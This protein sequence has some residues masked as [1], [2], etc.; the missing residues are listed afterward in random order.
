MGNFRAALV[1]ILA[2]L[3]MLLSAGPAFAQPGPPG[4]FP[5]PGH[6]PP[7][8]GQR[9]PPGM[10]P[11]G[12]QQPPQQ[13]PNQPTDQ[14]PV[15]HPAPKPRSWQEQPI[16]DATI[17]DAMQ[18]AIQFIWKSINKDGNWE[19]Y[20]Q[21]QFAADT[22]PGNQTAGSVYSGGTALILMSLLRAGISADDARWDKAFKSIVEAQ[23]AGT[24]ARSM[25]A[26]LFATMNRPKLLGKLMDAEKDYQLQAVFADGSYGY[27]PPT[28]RAD[29]MKP[30]GNVHRDMSAT[31][32]GILAMWLLSDAD[33]EMPSRYWK[34]I[35][36][37][38]LKSQNDDG[39]WGYRR[40][41]GK[42]ESYQAMTLAGVASLFVVW[43]K[44]YAA[45]CNRRPD[46]DLV[47]GI[48]KGLEWMAKH[49]DAG[50]G[51]GHP[52]W[53]RG[54]FLG[55]TLYGVERVAVAGGLKY[56]GK[57][58]W[59]DEGAR[60]LLYSQR[61]DGSWAADQNNNATA[62]V[63][64]AY[65][66]LFLSYGRAPVVFN[67]LAWS[68]A[69][70]WN[71][72]PR[73]LA[74]LTVWMDKTYERLFNWQVMPIGQ[75]LEELLDAPVLLISG[76]GELDFDDE[77]KQ[78]L[79]QYVLRGGMLLADPVGGDG[80]FVRSFTALLRE[81][82]G[83]LE[84]EEMENDHPLF[85][86]HFNLREPARGRMPVPKMFALSNGVRTLAV[87][88]TGELGCTWQSYNVARG[89]DIFRFGGNVMMYV[90][91]RGKGLLGRG[92]SYT[93]AD[94][95]K[96][97]AANITVGRLTW[98]GLYNWNPEPAAWTHV[99]LRLRNANVLGVTEKVLDFAGAVD[100][101]AVP[102]VHLTGVGELKL[103]DAQK[104]N[105]KAYVAGG[106]LLLA[107][108]AGGDPKFS[109]SFQKLAGELFGQLVPAVPPFLPDATDNGDV[110]LRHVG[111]LPR[112]VS[113]L[114][115]LGR[116]EEGGRW[117]VLFLPYDLTAALVGYPNLEPS[118][119]TPES[120]QK[121]V[122]ALLR[123]KLGQK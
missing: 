112:S 31:Q 89:E 26:A 24:Y 11:P 60:V 22:K 91:D 81:L 54:R 19:L 13:Q 30:P 41:V 5:P 17:D 46:K 116:Q 34:L 4:P 18:Q 70:R 75:P 61:A 114:N 8:P 88:P 44:L 103:T 52:G 42:E 43:D 118:G 33:V 123:W 63:Q 108:A 23:P 117:S 39:G 12:N 99:D 28:N 64:A 7:P 73:D 100:P 20:T 35:E 36:V 14:Q 83:E 48:E 93:V 92:S 32:Y 40:G 121:F 102:I 58:N 6:R 38:L 72:R 120:A 1:S 115:L 122:A 96:K 49:F 15:A 10:Q 90:S 110:T 21:Q 45:D 86:A 79:K 71:L 87:L 66:L 107:D 29:R 106:G 111:R 27:L 82:F 119:L 62:A 105:L 97:P 98:G 74:R 76:R 16:D 51:S 68:S 2:A 101:A 65:A 56:F 85:T 3:G 78:K 55:Y 109:E 50:Q 94:A 57:H 77:Q 113:R 69:D 67:K 47:T 59:W 53:P 95:G 84:L 37:G 80:V 9:P 104:A 25:R